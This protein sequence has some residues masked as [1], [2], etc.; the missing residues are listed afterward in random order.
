MVTIRLLVVLFAAL[1]LNLAAEA[2]AGELTG[3][4]IREIFAGTAANG[5]DLDDKA[6]Y[7]LEIAK[8]GSLRV[9]YNI[10]SPRPIILKGNWW[11]EG[12]LWCRT[13]RPSPRVKRPGSTKCQTVIVENG[14]YI[15]VDADGTRVSR[16]YARDIKK[17]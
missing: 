6:R 13:I 9:H 17:R 8:N 3:M 7:K 14:A 16:I 10:D 2:A 12:D 1:F 4:E 5:Y 15:F 11:I